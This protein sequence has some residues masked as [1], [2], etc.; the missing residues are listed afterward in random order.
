MAKIL[1]ITGA[2]LLLLTSSAYAQIIEQTR[3]LDQ[4]VVYSDLTQFG[5]WDDRNYAVTQTGS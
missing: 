1:V 4:G 2:V 3:G 5:P